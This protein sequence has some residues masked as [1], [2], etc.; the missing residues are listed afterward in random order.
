M[1]QFNILIIEALKNSHSQFWGWLCI[2]SGLMLVVWIC[3]ICLS[4]SKKK[5]VMKAVENEEIFNYLF[6]RRS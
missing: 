1:T 6:E 2:G 5:R 3:I 4:G